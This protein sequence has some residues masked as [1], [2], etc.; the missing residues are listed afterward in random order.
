[1]ERTLTASKRKRIYAKEEVCVGCR[2]CEIH[3]VVA[4][5]QYKDD[6]VK[7]YKKSPQRPL[8]RIV[9][10]ENKPVSFGLQCRHCDDPKCV[11]ACITGA[12][13]QDPETGL[14]TNDETRCIG[15]W[16]CIL[17]C[18][19]GVIKRD[20]KGKKVASKCD[21]CIESG[22][23]PACVKNC[24]SDALFVGNVEISCEYDSQPAGGTDK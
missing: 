2:L 11:K 3:C 5:S 24:P 13:Q 1:M 8:P 21:F 9:V 4:H 12:M 20:S 14:V 15:C 6:I 10:E 23:E 16:T 22:C 17:S 7:A 19:F 18:P